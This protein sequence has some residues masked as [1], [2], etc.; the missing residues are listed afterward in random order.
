MMLG[1]ARLGSGFVPNNNNLDSVLVNVKER[2]KRSSYYAGYLMR[3][4]D[5]EFF[6]GQAGGPRQGK[7]FIRRTH[8]KTQYM[9][10]NT[11]LDKYQVNHVHTHPWQ[12]FG[13]VRSIWDHNAGPTSSYYETSLKVTMKQCDKSAA[14]RTLETWGMKYVILDERTQPR[15]IDFLYVKHKLYHTKFPYLKAPTTM[16]HVGDADFDWKGEEKFDYTVHGASTKTPRNNFTSLWEEAKKAAGVN[17]AKIVAPAAK[18]A[19]A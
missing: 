6:Y 2:Y 13:I 10:W 15:N 1:A 4:P 3:N 14:V 7:F 18:K 9:H 5:R 8:R 12:G 16:G 11:L 19:A 17:K